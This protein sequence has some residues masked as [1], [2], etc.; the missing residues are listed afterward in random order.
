MAE[1]GDDI[2]CGQCRLWDEDNLKCKHPENTLP[3][4]TA[5]AHDGCAYGE[6]EVMESLRKH[7]KK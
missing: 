7:I 3:N 6:A 5:K 4:A 2:L 1:R